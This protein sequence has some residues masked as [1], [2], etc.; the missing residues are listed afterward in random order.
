MH[1]ILLGDPSHFRIKA[2][3]NPYTRTRW[4]LKKKVDL[5]KAIDQWRRFKEAL[6]EKGA[7]VLLKKQMGQ[8]YGGQISEWDY[9]G[10]FFAVQAMMHEGEKYWKKWWPK[11]RDHLVKI[12]NADGSWTIQ[13]CLCCRAYATALSVIVLQAPKRLLPLFQL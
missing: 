13:Y 10:A 6:L 8:D 12:Q 1:T 5:K 3:Q 9:C 4:G 7:E 2:G 11:F